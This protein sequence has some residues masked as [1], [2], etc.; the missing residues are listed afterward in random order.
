M[1]HLAV[2]EQAR[3][4]LGLRGVMFLPVGV[5][6]HKPPDI[7]PAEHR[8]AMIQAAIADNPAFHLSRREVDR[9]GPSYAVDTLEQLHAEFPDAPERTYWIMSMEALDGFASWRQPERVL[10]LCRVAVVPRLGHAAPDQG[11]LAGQFAGRE[12]RFVFLDGPELGDSASRIRQLVSQGRSVRYLVPDAVARYIN[13]HHLYAPESKATDQKEATAHVTDE[14]TPKA[15]PRRRRAAKP[16]SAGSLAKSPETG[17]SESAPAESTA[18]ESVAGEKAA[19]EDASAE[20]VAVESGLED[21]ASAAPTSAAPTSADRTPGLPARRRRVPPAVEAS[22]AGID[23]QLTE[24]ER[25]QAKAALELAHRIVELASDRK[26]ADIVLLSVA[27]MTTLTDYFVICSGGSE[28]QLGAIADGIV[29][30]TKAEGTLPIGREGA[31]NAH[32]LLIDYGSVIVHVMAWPER[33]FYALEKLWSEA[34][35][36]LRVQ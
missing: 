21:R 30:G 33:D 11:W 24:K 12:E 23:G 31:A 25:S 8:V 1:A 2:A 7:T 14:P 15:A 3:Q 5:P 4:A 13:D 22:E 9:P 29:E 27:E 16:P 36:L 32:W 26:A 28:R 34:P 17:Q 18:A 6:S 35:L 20:S 10:D 19:G